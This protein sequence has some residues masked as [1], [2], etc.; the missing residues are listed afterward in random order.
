MKR[1]KNYEEDTKYLKY[2]KPFHRERYKIHKQ[3]SK[4]NIG[5]W[6]FATLFLMLFVTILFNF[7]L[8]ENNDSEQNTQQT[9]EP[10]NQE[11]A[12]KSDIEMLLIEEIDAIRQAMPNPLPDDVYAT[13][14]QQA[15]VFAKDLQKTITLTP[16]HLLLLVDKTHSLSSDY[17]PSDIVA[18]NQ[19][20]ELTLNRNSLTLSEIVIEDLIDMSNAAEQA[21]IILPISSTYRSYDYQHGL[22]KRIA[23]ELGLEEASQQ[24]AR[25]GTSQHQLGTTVDFGSI[26]ESFEF[27][28]AGQWLLNNSR[29]F[30]FSLSYPKNMQA[31]TGYI[32]ESWHYRYIGRI[33]SSLQA[34]YFNDLQQYMLEFI[35]YIP[36]KE[37]N[38]LLTTH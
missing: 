16:S 24:S 28:Q 21:G 14:T 11:I 25:A 17:E 22:F 18:L 30:G 38:I 9:L 29:T 27:T 1:N 8:T 15:L 4:R 7:F 12:S 36:N 20:P 6:S 10:S 5:L 26:D 13:I 33:A 3:H 2:A 19:Y 34:L 23:N 35:H 31:I 32:F 37:H